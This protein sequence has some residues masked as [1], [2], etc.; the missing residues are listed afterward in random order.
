MSAT[1]HLD[2]LAVFVY[3]IYCLFSCV[4]QLSHISLV[5]LM[6]FFRYFFI[7]MGETI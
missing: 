3:P 5:C 4:N 7:A 6:H 1:K 2:F